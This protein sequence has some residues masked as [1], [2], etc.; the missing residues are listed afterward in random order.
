M[1]YASGDNQ[2][3]LIG[4]ALNGAEE[5]NMTFAV[6]GDQVAISDEVQTLCSDL[7][8]VMSTT[9]EFTGFRKTHLFEDVTE[10]I[11]FDDPEAGADSSGPIPP[12]C[13]VA[14]SFKTAT[15]SRRGRGRTYVP[16][17]CKGSVAA[18]TAR[19][20][21]G[22]RSA[23][24]TAFTDFAA[25]IDALGVQLGVNSRMDS[26]VRPVTIVRIGDVFDTIRRRRDQLVEGYTS[27]TL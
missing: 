17:I 23:I 16:G 20:S 18:D 19:L 5:F 2:I 7:S 3:T 12:Q 24:L 6:T 25:A 15:N 26:V 4:S 8:G 1:A 21:S 14:V 22:T 10:E 9:Y 11:T 27:A 13:A